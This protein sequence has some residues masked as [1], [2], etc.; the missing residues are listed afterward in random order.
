MN[1]KY[2]KQIILP[3]VFFI[4]IKKLNKVIIWFL[5]IRIFHNIFSALYSYKSSKL[6]QEINGQKFKTPVGMAAGFDSTGELREFF[7]SAGFGFVES[8]PF[9]IYNIKEIISNLLWNR[10]RY[11]PLFINIDFL[12]KDASIYAIEH[13]NWNIDC[14]YVVNIHNLKEYN[15]II[16]KIKQLTEKPVYIK[17]PVDIKLSIMK[18]MAKK[19]LKIGVG[20]IIASNQNKLSYA[21]VELK[22]K[23]LTLI[24]ESYKITKGVVPIIG[25]GGINKGSD[26]LSYIM[27]GANL[28]QMLSSY[29]Y[30]GPA[31]PKQINVY[32]HKMCAKHNCRL[33]DL[34]GI[35]N[36]KIGYNTKRKLLMWKDI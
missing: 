19:S 10:K 21:G 27:A 11:K 25:V 7:M 26:A 29:A 3:I 14:N 33:Q 34:T 12:H 16:P 4:G 9:S 13:V 8:G 17:V 22:T 18:Q 1:N 36:I 31:L 15:L 32:L 35:S 30:E 23:V 20:L 5:K 2:Y 24:K 6:V 28:V